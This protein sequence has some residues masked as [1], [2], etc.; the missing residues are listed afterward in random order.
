MYTD[1]LRSDPAVDVWM[2]LTEEGST[3]SSEEAAILSDVRHIAGQV[4]LRRGA[5]EKAVLIITAD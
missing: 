3:P 2:R 4:E 5:R 1:G